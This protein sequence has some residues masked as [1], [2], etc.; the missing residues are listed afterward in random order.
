MN[1]NRSVFHSTV[2]EVSKNEGAKARDFLTNMP[3]VWEIKPNI[4]E[5]E[6][7]KWVS[8]LNSPLH[9]IVTWPWD[10]VKFIPIL[11]VEYLTTNKDKRMMIVDVSSSYNSDFTHIGVPSISELF[12]NSVFFDHSFSN[13]E[14]SEE[15]KSEMK[16]LDGVD[17]IQ[18]K[19]VTEYEIRKIGQGNRSGGDCT[20]SFLKCKNR[21]RKEL[22]SIYGENCIRNLDEIKLNKK[23]KRSRFNENGVVDLK[24]T[25]IEKYTGKLY[26]DKRWLWN[27]LLQ[28]PEMRNPKKLIS[29]ISIHTPFPDL[30]N[31]S[32]KLTFINLT[33]DPAE[34]FE[35]IDRVSPDLLVIP[36]TDE[37]IRDRI[38]RGPKSKSLIRF[39]KT[40]KVSAVLM[41][42]TNKDIR[43][44]YHLYDTPVDVNCNVI[45]H[46][47]DNDT[48]L[49]YLKVNGL[50][51]ES[52]YSNSLSSRWKELPQTVEL[53]P[54]IE[55]VPIDELN[56]LDNAVEISKFL[57]NDSLKED[58]RKFVDE[59]QKSPL[60][61]KGSQNQ[62]EV[63]RRPG[64]ALSSI[65]YETVMESLRE[66]IEE[67]H[68][69]RTEEIFTSA[70]KLGS[71]RV[72]PI[73]D[74]VVG[75]IKE[76]TSSDQA[77]VTFVVN[78]F[79]VRGVTQLLKNY[80]LEENTSR[81]LQICSWRDLQSREDQI[82]KNKE[83]VVIAT[84]YPDIDYSVYHS[85]VKKY[86]FVGS[87]RN[88][89]KINRV[90]TNRMTEPRSRP[91]QPL[92]DAE[93][94]P[95][96]LKNAMK[97][98][99][100]SAIEGIQE[101]L[102]DVT[103]EFGGLEGVPV[104]S[105]PRARHERYSKINSGEEAVLI[106]NGEGK[107]MFVK[108]DETVTVKEGGY[109]TEKEL[110]PTNKKNLNKDLIGIE[111]L[112]D[113]EGFH[114]SFKSMFLKYMIRWARNIKF[115]KGVYE[116]NGFQD[117]YSSS[118]GW[119]SY[120]NRSINLYSEINRLEYEEAEEFMANFLSSLKLI[121]SNP[122]YIRRWWTDYE[123]TT[124]EN[125]DYFIYSIEHTKS[126]EDT[127]K[128][129]I[130][131]NKRIPEANLEAE[132]VE[133]SYTASVLLQEFRR[134]FLRSNTI[135]QQFRT[136]QSQ[137]R[138]EITAEIHESSFFK[139]VNAFLVNLEKEVPRLRVIEN[140]N[141]YIESH[142][143]TG[144]NE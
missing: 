4:I 133:R 98:V 137:V 32:A 75:I 69:K 134:S 41:F 16:N 67:S 64:K 78:G 94:A 121:A 5:E 40:N 27:C 83:N 8:Q 110:K 126:I 107:G 79:D 97:E 9:I 103:I 77:Y 22:S 34:M 102:K 17:V 129:C 10:T 61:L 26:Y 96:L 135:D 1:L 12:R 109:I 44:L 21:F 37:L 48:V 116:W 62:V 60:R 45:S 42:S 122:S 104:S 57:Q 89:E 125:R 55:L 101:E 112:I 63:F 19:V 127:R 85:P 141:E 118:V 139:V 6:Y 33:E 105:A 130:G 51:Y 74:R 90:I 106:I 136:I 43:H 18:R 108:V 59:L 119:I 84:T 49:N 93:Q 128:I 82:V 56:R 81:H 115:R 3:L 88:L 28:S 72:T 117:L 66:R 35:Y 7:I 124:I 100:L 140:Y 92:L 29:N 11:A 14:I 143:T 95:L 36:D 80:E 123:L 20:E 87:N 52:R 76:L 15:I 111:I 91:V 114:R 24:L 144:N 50:G 131:I 53:K 23:R 142:I 71:Y 30:A 13:F 65:T 138:R 86:I 39:L 25:E 31:K 120:I 47:W 113:V 2:E 46:T 99:D 58:I 132:E 68:F 73:L 54:S 70:Y 38:I